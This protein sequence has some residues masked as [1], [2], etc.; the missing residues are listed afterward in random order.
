[1]T[2]IAS[3]DEPKTTERRTLGV[4]CGAHALHDGYTELIYVLLPLWQA[5]FGLSYAAAGMLRTTFSGTMASLQIPASVAAERLGT[6]LV[7]AVGTALC[8]FCFVL[9]GLSAGFFLLVA[10]LFLGGLGAST[11][12]PLGSALVAHAFSGARSLK[13]LGTYNFAGDIGKMVLPVIGSLMLYVLPWRATAAILGIVGFVGAVAILLLLPNADR[14]QQ[15]RAK[16]ESRAASDD[17]AANDRTGFSLLL[18][19]G[20]LDGVVRAGFLVFL[21]FLMIGKGASV[22]AAGLALTT[23][24]VGG[25][26]GKLACAWLGARFGVI[27]A[28]I[29]TEALTSASLLAVLYA[30]LV[31]CFLILPIA[32]AML[33]GTSSLTYGSVPRFVTA[34][35]RARAFGVFYTG[36]LVCSALSPTLSGFVGDRIG[37]EATIVL[38]AVFALTTVPIALLLRSRFATSY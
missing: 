26:V 35:N 1:M 20:A 11:Q 2:T 34:E 13:A 18:T 28:V 21:P 38:L 24:F 27:G 37:L 17:P 3:T 14:G 5:E 29:V 16:T 9:A 19:L 12:H 6:A 7:L 8:G 4:A 32:G 31:V 36:T 30:P 25:A 15:Q 23:L 33:N 10:A 22:Q